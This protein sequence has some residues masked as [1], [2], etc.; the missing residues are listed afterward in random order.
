MVI[1]AEDSF[2]PPLVSN[3]PVCERQTIDCRQIED[4]ALRPYFESFHVGLVKQ[5]RAERESHQWRLV[6]LVADHKIDSLIRSRATFLLG[7]IG[8]E[9][10]A[11][12]PLLQ[13]EL[14]NE[15]DRYMQAD[16]A[17]AVIKICPSDECAICALLGCL[18]ESDSK[19][20]M[21]AAF[22]L[23]NVDS[24]KRLDVI[25]S[26]KVLL[27]SNDSR[28]QRQTLLTLA[29]FGPASASA[30]PEIEAVLVNADPATREVARMSLSC[31]VRT[32]PN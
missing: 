6:G 18:K 29:E 5:L 22:A 31:I 20:Q 1:A 4:V 30:I 13:H 7:E 27:R 32:L 17:E 25:D 2:V 16:L 11:T 8:P 24:E 19:L 9:A 26:L 28:L 10:I 12:L 3:E 21:I 14:C 15:S 23:H